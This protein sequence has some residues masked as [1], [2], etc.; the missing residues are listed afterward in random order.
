MSN[1]IS[2]TIVAVLLTGLV[3][4]HAI[5]DQND[6]K[7]GTMWAPNDDGNST[8]YTAH[9]EI[10][11][12]DTGMN[13][14]KFY[15]EVLPEPSCAGYQ[16]GWG[17]TFC[18]QTWGFK[19]DFRSAPWR[20]WTS[21][22]SREPESM[23]VH[24]WAVRLDT[25]SPLQVHYQLTVNR[26]CTDNQYTW[27][28]GDDIGYAYD[29]WTSNSMSDLS[30]SQLDW[31]Q[32]A[33]VTSGYID[34]ALVLPPPVVGLPSLTMNPQSAYSAPYSGIASQSLRLVGQAD[35][36]QGIRM[37]YDD[38]IALTMHANA[39]YPYEYAGNTWQSFLLVGQADGSIG[40]RMYYD[41]TIALTMTAG[42]LYPA[43]YQ[44]SMWQSLALSRSVWVDAKINGLP[45]PPH[46]V[47]NT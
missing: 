33:R 21:P 46:L 18:S 1:K 15:F 22:C 2:S 16:P 26:D 23:A 14:E 29:G 30:G 20:W 27:R 8:A 28:K 38:T 42:Q 24:S 41:P 47:L 31:Y 19:A 40:I 7:R 6:Q 34:P 35:G 32:V 43:P 39:V 10:D 12:H 45:R 17:P 4:T 5:A 9:I 37:Y 11:G 36:S 25:W 13:H 3:T 44:G